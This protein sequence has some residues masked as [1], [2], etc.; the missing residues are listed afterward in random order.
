MKLLLPK[1]REWV[2]CAALLVAL[3]V[4]WLP[5]FAAVHE[6]RHAFA[7]EQAALAHPIASCPDGEPESHRN[8]FDRERGTAASLNCDLCAFFQ[9]AAGKKGWLA[10]AAVQQPVPVIAAAPRLPDHPQAF[11]KI[12]RPRGRSPPSSL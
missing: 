8:H 9:H 5:L 12:D 1:Y 2:S 4:A 3:H 11:L 10:Q 6:T 7:E